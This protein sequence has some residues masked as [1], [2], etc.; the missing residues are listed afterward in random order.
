MI[1]INERTQIRKRSREQNRNT[2]GWLSWAKD[3]HADTTLHLSSL[4][5]TNSFS[6][7][8]AP[9]PKQSL[10]SLY[11]S[12]SSADDSLSPPLIFQSSVFSVSSVFSHQ[13]RR[14]C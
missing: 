10:Y 1:E 8:T 9:T 3:V 14:H 5:L 12:H 6:L 7:P 2:W 11:I 4:S 13:W